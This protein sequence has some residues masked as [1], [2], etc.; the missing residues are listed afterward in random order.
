[1]HEDQRHEGEISPLLGRQKQKIRTSTHSLSFYQTRSP[2]HVVGLLSICTFCL[3]GASAFLNVPVTRLIED[4]LC[5]RYLGNSHRQGSPIDE[6]LCKTDQI[7]SKLAYLNGSLALVEALVSLVAAF[8]FGVLADILGRKPIILLSSVGSLLSL[9][10]VLAVIALPQIISV[11]FILAGPLFTVVGGG[12]TVLVANLYSILS[13]VV[14]DTDRASA[15]FYMAFASLVGASVGPA[16]SSRLM[17]SF[18]PW[19]P[20]LFGFFAV[21]IGVSVL[22]F[23]PETFA[24]S[25]LDPT[26]EE[27]HAGSGEA[28]P[29]AFKSHLTQSLRLLK[30]SFM[31]LHSPSLV[32]VLATFLTCMPESLAT[33]QLF[34][35][36]VSKRFDWPLSKAGY[37]LTIRGI[38]QMGV[39]LVALPLLSKLLLQWQHPAGKDLTL[40][41]VSATFAASGSLYIAAS[42]IGLVISGITLHTFGA[43]LAPLCRSLATSYLAPQDTSKLNTL[44]GIIET[45]GSLFA[46]P[47]LAWLFSMGMKLKGAWLGLPYFALA[48]LFVLCLLVLFGVSAPQRD[49]AEDGYDGEGGLQQRHP[50]STEGDLDQEAGIQQT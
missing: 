22:A 38:V 29:N 10:W 12:S 15:F 11:Q 2:S 5:R 26:R 47:A 28:Q 27:E 33:S 20:A 37:L 41:R 13:D 48:A 19:V 30:V 23:V 1:M 8:P 32:L 45:T 42:Q 16:I 4:N 18:S 3:A 31:M 14:P 9:A 21:P 35:Q 40:A 25:K 39:L 6:R 17:E 34:T 36:Y 46:G 44:I 50:R 7:Q 49:G 24:P 43:G